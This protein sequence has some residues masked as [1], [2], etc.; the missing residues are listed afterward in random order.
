MLLDVFSE[1][2][3]TPAPRLCANIK[4]SRAVRSARKRP[5]KN[6]SPNVRRL[7]IAALVLAVACT[8][9]DSVSQTAKGSIDVPPHSTLLL[10]AIGSGDQVYGCVHGGW[11][12]N[13]P[14]AKLLDQEDLSLGDTLQVL[15]GNSLTAAGSREKSSPSRLLPIRPECRGYCLSLSTA[16]GA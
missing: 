16:P 4:P 15:L 11:V 9:P 3:F 5:D 7:G 10:R 12:L 14:E 8:A 2:P 6:Q 1:I 13:A